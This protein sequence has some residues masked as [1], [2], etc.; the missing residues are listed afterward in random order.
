[1]R[2]ILIRICYR[3]PQHIYGKRRSKSK[4]YAKVDSQDLPQRVEK[5]LMA[6]I[7]TVLHINYIPPKPGVGK[8]RILDDKT[9]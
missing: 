7:T 5:L 4:T 3:L 8:T 9:R 2:R 6:K 1:V